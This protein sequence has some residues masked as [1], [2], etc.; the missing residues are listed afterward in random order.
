MTQY[1]IRRFHLLPAFKFGSIIGAIVMFLPGLTF[2]WLLRALIGV[3]YRWLDS[4][5]ELDVG[6]FGSV[7][8]VDLLNLSNFLALLERLDGQ[9]TMLI[10][11]ITL[12]AVLLGGLLVGVMAVL[13]ALT[14]NFLAAVSGGLV[15]AAD[16]VGQQ[17]L[18]AVAGGWQPGSGTAYLPTPPVAQPSAAAWLGVAPTF[19][20][21]WPVTAG[22]TTIGSGPNNSVVLP[23]L[24]P[25][26][27]EIRYE[28]GR[29]VLYPLTPDGVWVN[30]RP[31][32]SMNM[33]R[34]GFTIHL[35]QHELKFLGGA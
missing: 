6:L 31:V 19:Q 28:G 18:P 30:G 4:W 8:L 34:D 22:V 7:S 26:H 2:G 11:A 25:H 20:P 32:N 29:F 16:V 17:P 23:G 12:A 3:L 15:V 35:G 33:I 24:A 9:G 1:I 21:T 10:L 5:V 14:Y 13:A 27:A